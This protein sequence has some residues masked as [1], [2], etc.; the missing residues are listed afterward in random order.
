MFHPWKDGILAVKLTKP[1]TQ[2]LAN[3]VPLLQQL[4]SMSPINPK[5]SVASKE[6]LAAVNT[7]IDVA[8]CDSKE[9]AMPLFDQPPE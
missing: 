9:K 1:E 4:A 8:G 6:A 3:A 7:V 5:L 2:K